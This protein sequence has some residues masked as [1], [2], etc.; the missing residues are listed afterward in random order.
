MVGSVCRGIQRCI[1]RFGQIINPVTKYIQLEE[2]LAIRD[3]II[4][5][6]GGRKGI[7][8]FTLLHSAIE[9][10]KATFAGK[11][12]YPNVFDKSTAYL[13]SLIQNHPFND[14][15]KRTAIAVTVLFLYING[16][17]LKHTRK[18][19]VDLSLDIQKH[20][21]KFDQISLWLKKHTNPIK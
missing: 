5:F 14:G 7:L 15:N 9:R 3:R 13:H 6:S 1:A 10:P 19:I 16:Y 11:D 18:E 17:S 21:Y 2:V 20:K 12:L 8:D 4:D